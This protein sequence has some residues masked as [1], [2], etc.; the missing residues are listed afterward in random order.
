MSSI[1]LNFQGLLIINRFE[2]IFPF[3]FNEYPS[4]SVTASV[5]QW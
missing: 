5:A 1:W 2:V 4:I 3:L